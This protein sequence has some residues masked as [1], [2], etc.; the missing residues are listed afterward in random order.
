MAAARAEPA[1]WRV[2]TV[3]R[4]FDRR[5]AVLRDSGL[6]LREVE[7]RLLE[8]LDYVRL[9][10]RRI[11]DVGCGGGASA[12]VLAS[13][14]PGAFWVGVDLSLA[15]L[16]AGRGGWW[17]RL[18]ERWQRPLA[19]VCADAAA[20]PVAEGG[21]DLLISNLMLHWHPQPQRVL[22]E[23]HRVLAADGLLLFTCFGPD[24]L[25]ELRTACAQ[26]LPQARPLPYIDMHDYGDILVAAGFATPVMDMEIVRFTYDTP[27]ALLSEVRRLGG[28][29]RDDRPAGLP[30]GARARALR[31]ALDRQRDAQGRI[32]L[33]FEIVYAH[34]WRP[35]PRRAATQVIPLDR[36]RGGLRAARP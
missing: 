24:T 29:P 18:R 5:A 36:L 13:R 8:R 21:F 4:Q 14:Y 34:A 32:A 17:A 6:L 27:E 7:R 30:S 22:S 23:W 16:A 2:Q 25:R 31:Q 33:T 12:A 10:P 35:P 3:R 11:L 9:A 19:R 15:A 26:A 1:P 28:N 20:L